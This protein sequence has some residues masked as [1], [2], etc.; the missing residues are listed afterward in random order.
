MKF[1]DVSFLLVECALDAPSVSP[2]CHRHG[3]LAPY[4]SVM[5][6]SY[7]DGSKSQVEVGVYEHKICPFT[8]GCYSPSIIS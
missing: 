3:Q 7:N 8:T 6:L 1:K 2:G 4:A 5:M